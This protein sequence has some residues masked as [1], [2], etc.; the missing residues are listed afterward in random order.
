[1]IN[2]TVGPVQASDEVCAIGAEQ[3]PYFRTAEFSDIMLENEKLIKKFAKAKED[4]RAVFITGSGTA[5][6]EAVIINTL[7]STDKA[8]VVNGGSFG[9]RFV[10]LCKVHSVPFSEI[11]LEMG[12][13]LTR[14]MLE[15]YDNKGYTAFI[16]NVHETSTGVYYD[17][18]MISEF[19]KKNNLFLI[20]DA[21]SSFLA[22]E[23]DME[24]LCVDVMITGSQKALACP[25]GISVIVLDKKAIDRVEI[26]DPKSMYFD[27]KDAL[28]NGER[29]QTPF[30]P[31]VGILRQINVRLKEIE[32]TGGVENEITKIAE[33]AADFREK[34]QELP[35]E[36]VSESMSNAVTPL[37]PTTASANDIFRILKDE[38]QIWVC[39]NGGELKDQVFR[40]GH[41]GALTKADNTILVNAL[42]DMQKRKLI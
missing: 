31:A 18:N 11:T 23:F 32:T 29:G 6:M 25:P 7:T 3:V 5:S 8:I 26:S 4:A 39:P 9:Q 12:K 27:L 35:F 41:L 42:K 28:K 15:E 40:V 30:T 19:C 22:D 24:K 36:I 20:V 33:I 16:V 1:M 17:I 21:I 34:I 2:F 14:E 38:Y 13:A 37:H 10:Q